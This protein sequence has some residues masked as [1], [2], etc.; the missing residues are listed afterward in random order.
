MHEE[1]IDSHVYAHIHTYIHIQD[2]RPSLETSM[3]K[4]LR[5]EEKNKG[6]FVIGLH[7]YTRNKYFTCHVHTYIHI[8]IHTYKHE[9]DFKEGMF[10]VDMNTIQLAGKGKIDHGPTHGHL[11]VGKIDHGPTRGHLYVGKIDH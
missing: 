5:R 8:Y 4:A 1:G 3:R 10:V 6:T 2:R 7:T 11:Y 9:K